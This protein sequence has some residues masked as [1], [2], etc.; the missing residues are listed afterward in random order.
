MAKRRTW[1]EL[2]NPSQH[3]SETGYRNGCGCDPCRRAHNAAQATS[4]AKKLGQLGLFD[5]MD[6]PLRPLRKIR[7]VV[8]PGLDIAAV[9]AALDH[10]TTRWR[11][12]ARCRG[13]LD[14][15]DV[16]HKEEI[17]QVRPDGTFAYSAPGDYVAEH[18]QQWCA[19]CP[20]WADCVASGLAHETARYRVGF[21]GSTPGQRGAIAV[22][23]RSH[24]AAQEAAT[25]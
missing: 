24:R 22:A 16:F 25:A 4:R 5:D 17:V 1:I 9:A 14:L 21:Y 12:R 23:V 20:A 8:P 19:G 7:P 18:W 15:L 6:Q 10:P 11:E 2:A 13:H 3:G